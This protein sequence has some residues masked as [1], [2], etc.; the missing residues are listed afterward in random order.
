M[1]NEWRNAQ[2]AAGVG[3]SVRFRHNVIGEAIPV[4]S[5]EKL[6]AFN[7]LPLLAAR[8]QQSRC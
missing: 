5:P 6:R 8:I 3:E 7:Q 4:T 2:E 1:R